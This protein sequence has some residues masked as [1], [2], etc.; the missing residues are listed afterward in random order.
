MDAAELEGSVADE[1]HGEVLPLVLDLFEGFVHQGV[2]FRQGL[3]VFAVVGGVVATRSSLR[4]ARGGAGCDCVRAAEMLLLR[5]RM[6]GSHYFHTDP[7]LLA[8]CS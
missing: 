8:H 6:V 2:D 7:V 1:A 4:A 3:L 5:K